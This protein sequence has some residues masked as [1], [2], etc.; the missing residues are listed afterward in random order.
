MSKGVQNMSKQV[1]PL[2]QRAP[3]RYELPET[4]KKGMR[5]PGILW[6]NEAAARLIAEDQ[7]L[8]QLAN[9]ACLPGIVGASH[10]MPDIHAGYGFPIGGVAAFRTD[11]GVISPGGV[12]YD[13]NCGVRL[14]KTSITVEDVRPHIEELTRRLQRDVP[15]GLAS[16][17]ELSLSAADLRDVM[18]QGAQ[19]AVDRGMGELQDL[20]FCE[21]RGAM[22]AADPNAVSERAVKR[23]RNQLGTLGSGNHFLE[24]CYVDSVYDDGLAEAFGL[25]YHTVCVMVHSGSRGFGHQ[26]CTDYVSIMLKAMTKHGIHVPDRQ[27]ACAPFDSDEGQKYYSAMACAANFAWANRQVLAHLVRGV[28]SGLFPGIKVSTVYDVAHNIARVEKHVVEGRPL[29]L[30]VHRKGA[31]KAL[32]P[33]NS[34]LPGAYSRYGQPILV[35]GDMGRYSYVLAGTVKAQEETFGSTCHGAGRLLSREAAKKSVDGSMLKATLRDKGIFV[36]GT[37]NASLAE[38]APEAYKDVSE[39]VSVM[40]DAGL[41]RKVARLVP[42]GVVKG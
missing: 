17:G 1:G 11:S 31:T 22:Q 29:E 35:P 40:V 26:I 3:Y 4:Y 12:G 20:E 42:I 18:V 14:M 39:V 16:E 8:D 38:E 30:I 34:L 9:V 23:G 28:M 2:L 41:A 24:V 25:R 10:G 37:S 19:W 36:L 15:S 33:G 7:S 27:L 13:I 21:D 32:G 6:V 5:V